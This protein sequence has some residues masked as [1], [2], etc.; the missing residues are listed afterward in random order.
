MLYAI[1]RDFFFLLML[2]NTLLL[3]TCMCSADISYSIPPSV[4]RHLPYD[5]IR[6]YTVLIGD[7]I[8]VPIL[9]HNPSLSSVS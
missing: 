5:L 4:V 3:V 9:R 8:A 6:E 2:L 7:P 1:K